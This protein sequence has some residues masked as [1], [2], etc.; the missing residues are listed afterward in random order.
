MVE[1]NRTPG[2]TPAPNYLNESRNVDRAQPNRAFEALFEGVG[3]TLKVGAAAKEQSDQ[4]AIDQAVYQSHDTVTGEVNLANMEVANAGSS[5]FFQTSPASPEVDDAVGRIQ[6]LSQARGAGKISDTYYWSQLQT[7]VQGLRSKYPNQ[8]DYIDQKVSQVTGGTPAN[9]LRNSLQQDLARQQQKVESQQTKQ[10]TFVRQNLGYIPEG[11][12]KSYNEGNPEAFNQIQFTVASRQRDEQDVAANKARLELASSQGKATVEM[13]QQG[14]SDNVNMVV[15]RFITDRASR[16]GVTSFNALA[17]RIAGFTGTGKSPSAEEQA[18]IL[19]QFSQLKYELGTQI[20]GALTAPDANGKSWST[21]LDPTRVKQLEEQGMAQ[22]NQLEDLLVNQQ[23]GLVNMVVNQQKAQTDARVK[24]LLDNYPVFQN[25]EALKRIG[26]DQ[27]VSQSL[28]VGGGK[29]LNDA[30]IALIQAQVTDSAATGSKPMDQY[31]QELKKATDKDPAAFSTMVNAHVNTLMAK[32]TNPEVALNMARSMFGQNNTVFIQNFRTNQD[33]MAVFS[34][35]SSPEVTKKMQDLSAADP[36]VWQNYSN[37]SKGAFLAVFGGYIDG[38][39]E[40]VNSR[41]YTDVTYDPVSS[42]FSW[43]MTEAGRASQRS[44]TGFVS[45]GNAL[46]SWRNSTLDT[47][48]RELNRGISLIRPILEAEGSDVNAEIMNLVKSK[49]LDTSTNRPDSFWSKLYRGIV[50]AEGAMK[51]NVSDSV[52]GKSPTG[53][54]PFAAFFGE[55]TA[56][57]VN[58]RSEVAVLDFIGG[59]EAAGNYNAISGNAKNQEPLDKLTVNQVFE[60]Q[61][62]MKSNPQQGF[63]SSAVGRYQ[64][65]NSTLKGLISELNIDGEALFTPELQDRLGHA[66]LE[67]RGLSRYRSGQLSREDFAKNLSQEW[68]SLPLPSGA[69]FY[70]SDGVNK[71]TVSYEDFL[72]ALGN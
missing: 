61:N 38:T 17:D 64:F 36:T 18:Q 15:S 2:P 52:R 41:P 19:A 56:T 31:A 63:L 40:G 3:N 68:A 34:K 57:P 35:M 23:Y 30:T 7:T 58:P 8:R 14:A 13:A 20:R 66:L 33:K 11:L 65:I 1:F 32:D 49:G 39:Q 22:L 50:S 42:Q 47:S 53:G 71:A 28:S 21:Y 4:Q 12:L 44:L 27:L 72:G 59:A 26:G 25:I 69:S 24:G 55:W 9:Q 5:N 70:Q 29:L 62:Y 46:D 60:L 48:I 54:S 16:A 67:R 45:G 51:Q 10:D 37:W 43:N 6:R